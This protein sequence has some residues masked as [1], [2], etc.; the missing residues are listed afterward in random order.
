MTITRR[1]FLRNTAASAAVAATVAAPAIAEAATVSPL[2]RFNSAVDA[3]KAAAMELDPTI[4]QWDVGYA[5]DPRLSCRVR[6]T[7]YNWRGDDDSGP[8]LA[9]DVTG[10]TAYAD[11]EARRAR[12]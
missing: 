8:L 11:W 5:A 1:L 2:E 6:I 10:A 3:L 4:K 12:P 9:D 7:A